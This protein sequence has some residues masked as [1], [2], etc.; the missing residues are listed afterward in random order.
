[1]TLRDVYNK[2]IK[3]KVIS[4]SEP[5]LR[6]LVAQGKIPYTEEGTKKVFDYKEVKRSL[7]A[8]QQKTNGT[9]LQPDG[10]NFNP[11]DKDGKEKTI[12]S[13]KI[14]LQDY[15]GKLAQ[16]KF[17]MEAGKLVD[18]EEVERK[19]FIVARV[20]R[21]QFL[22]LPERITA[23]IMSATNLREGKEIL[24]AEINQ[25][26]QFLSDESKLYE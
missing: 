19:S 2:L 16:Q 3:K 22:A 5:Y 7:G 25:L 11:K 26:L 4:Y 24:H 12:N 6:K 1:M 15:Q 20:L 18:R 10:T 21:D 9:Q 8:L 13:T 23:D 17:D 14:R